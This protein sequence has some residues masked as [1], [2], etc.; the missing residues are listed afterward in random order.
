M[1]LMIDNYDSF[2]YNLVQYLGELKADVKV[3]RNDEISIA[4]I[5]AL[6]PEKIVIS[7]GP[8]TPN[9]AGV[10]VEAIKTFAGKIPLLGVCLGHQSIGQ[11]FGG[12]VIRAPYVMHGKTSAVYHNNTGVFRGLNNPFQA[13]RYHS[14]VV[15]KATLP[16]C[17]EITAWTQNEDGSMGE[18][19]GVKHKTLAV[20]GVQFHPESILTEHGHDMLR[21]FLEAY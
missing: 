15:E 5:A 19:M 1:I 3:V 7:P 14:L 18:I 13:T 21:N 11:A 20:E 10:S 6:A 2:T 16:E 4:E 9:E 8:C 17:L 12:K